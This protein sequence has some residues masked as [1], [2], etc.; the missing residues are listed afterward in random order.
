M[1]FSLEYNLIIDIKFLQNLG[2]Y[3]GNLREIAPP[4]FIGEKSILRWGLSAGPLICVNGYELNP[5]TNECNVRHRLPSRNYCPN[6]YGYDCRGVCV[7]G[8]QGKICSGEYT[9]DE[10]IGRCVKYVEV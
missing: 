6:G 3:H 9:C 4:N 1:V 2:K 5:E 8:G 7:K 10:A